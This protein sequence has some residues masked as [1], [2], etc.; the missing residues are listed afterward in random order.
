M[1]REIQVAMEHVKT[2]QNTLK[3][4]DI[5]VYLQLHYHN[6]NISDQPHMKSSTKLVKDKCFSL[7]T[8]L[9]KEHSDTIKK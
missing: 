6:C 1:A 5:H 8:S 9:Q 4:E 3:S 7:H 2:C